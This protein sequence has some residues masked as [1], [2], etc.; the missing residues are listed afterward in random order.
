M[1]GKTKKQTSIPPH[2]LKKKIEELKKI[3]DIGDDGNETNSNTSIDTD[4]DSLEDSESDS[5]SSEEDQM[6]NLK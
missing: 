6:K 4:I 3:I 1:D 2:V 5:E